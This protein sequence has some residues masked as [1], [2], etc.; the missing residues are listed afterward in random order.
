[1]VPLWF[2]HFANI[3]SPYLREAELYFSS[4]TVPGGPTRLLTRASKSLIK[5][6]IK[7]E[8][9][10][11]KDMETRSEAVSSKIAEIKR[12]LEE[13]K[14]QIE[15]EEERKNS[16]P[17]SLPI[18]SS[19]PDNISIED[20]LIVESIDQLD[21]VEV[22]EP[23]APTFFPPKVEEIK[24]EKVE[25]KKEESPKYEKK[26]YRKGDFQFTDLEERVIMVIKSYKN[27]ISIRDITDKIYYVGSYENSGRNGNQDFSRNVRNAVRR[28]I[29]KGILA[30]WHTVDPKGKKGYLCLAERYK[31]D[32]SSN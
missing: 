27:P 11:R 4:L 26:F 30:R 28:P 10:R 8:W 1:M 5:F 17:P 14:R 21:D 25:D 24:E 22:E 7:I 13:K 29:E 19:E 18:R 12:K 9:H 20:V 15:L 2:A 6:K 31:K 32:E 3:F 23:V 16:T